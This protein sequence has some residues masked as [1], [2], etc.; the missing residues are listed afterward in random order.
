MS[1]VRR[2]DVRRAIIQRGS[3]ERRDQSARPG[4]GWPMT[5]ITSLG[6]SR[7]AQAIRDGEIGALEAVDAH[8]ERIEE[9]NS[10]LNAV[11]VKRYDAARSEAA[12]IDAMR[13]RGETLPPLAGVPI[14][15]KESIEVS[16]TPS[17]FGLAWRANLLAPEDD[18]HV[19]RLRAAGACVV[20]KTNVSQMLMYVEADNAV[21]GRTSNPWNTDRTCGGSSGGEG[22]IIAALG[23]A[24]GVGTDLG[25]SLRYPAAFCGVHTIRPT[26]GRCNSLGRYSVSAGQQMIRSQVGP[27]GRSTDDIELGLSLLVQPP[28]SRFNTVPNLGNSKSVEMSK[29]RVGWY[30]EDGTISSAP[31]VRRAVTE[32]AEALRRSGASVVEWHVPEAREVEYLFHAIISADAGRSLREHLKGEALQAAVKLWFASGARSRTMLSVLR[33]LLTALGQREMARMTLN[34]GHAHVA[35]YWKLLIALDEYRGRFA[36]AAD[37]A[38]GGAL[39]LVLGPVCPIP[40]FRHGASQR[41]GLVGANALLYSALGWPAGVSPWTTVRADEETDRPKS[42][43]FFLRTL[44][45]SEIGSA[46]LPVGVQIAAR[47]WHEH[48]AFAAMRVLDSARNPLPA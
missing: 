10:K 41:I 24:L 42:I 7:L 47:P 36:A 35:E 1:L 4:G 14:T 18:A 2:C 13:Q 30:V 6:A 45:A 11:V 15:V 39:D 23:S 43:D 20:G 26:A 12:A 17:T 16:G 21:Y 38:D 31:A 44:R 32:A 34:F 22:A 5:Y 40:A 37:A 48:Q 3:Y 27:L 33:G 29:L 8:I 25:G 46:G 19:S 28:A 9:V